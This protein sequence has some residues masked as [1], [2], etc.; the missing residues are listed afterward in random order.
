[1]CVYDQRL[2]RGLG[3]SSVAGHLSSTSNA[4]GFSSQYETKTV[5]RDWDMKPRGPEKGNSFHGA[6][7]DI[8]IS[9]IILQVIHIH[10]VEMKGSAV[11]RKSSIK[12]AIQV[13]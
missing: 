6:Q 4:F 9:L 3:R 13:L 12:L 8:I 10:S 5:W 11:L 2:L 7:Q 1:M